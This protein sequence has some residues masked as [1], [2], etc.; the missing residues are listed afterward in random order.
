MLVQ[1]PTTKSYF[2]KR[3][4]SE[5]NGRACRWP[6][7]INLT[8]SEAQ[9]PPV[10]FTP[11]SKQTEIPPHTRVTTQSQKTTGI[12]SRRTHQWDDV[13]GDKQS[14]WLS[15]SWPTLFIMVFSSDYNRISKKCKP[16]RNAIYEINLLSV[17]CITI[18]FT[19]ANTFN[20]PVWFIN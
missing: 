8:L 1:T 6:N 9:D 4:R 14:S 20:Q 15:G 17:D 7:Q 3:L 10:K 13:I 19:N 11:A 12:L 16:F 18:W 2:S 5:W